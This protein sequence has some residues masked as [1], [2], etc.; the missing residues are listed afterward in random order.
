MAAALDPIILQAR[1]RMSRRLDRDAPYVRVFHSKVGREQSGFQPHH[2]LRLIYVKCKIR[3]MQD[4]R[5]YT[6][7][8]FEQGEGS[9][10]LM[11]KIES[12]ARRSGSLC[13]EQ[14]VRSEEG[15]DERI[16]LR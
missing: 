7:R 6:R 5:V 11:L 13:R 15:G 10:T 14:V 16:A 4:A 2:Q 12:P 9:G 8:R 1:S 3:V